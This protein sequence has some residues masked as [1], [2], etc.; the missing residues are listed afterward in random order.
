MIKGTF[1]LVKMIVLLFILFILYSLGSGLFF[2]VRDKS[3]TDRVAKALT[4]RIGLSLLLFILL[5]IAF[6]LGW[7]KPH[8]V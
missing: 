6:A 2:L 8:G 3:R 5:F 7:I 4:W 1:M